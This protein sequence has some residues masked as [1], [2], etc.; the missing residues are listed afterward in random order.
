MKNEVKSYSELIAEMERMRRR[1][2]ELEILE[3]EQK[4]KEKS[5]KK[6]KNRLRTIIDASKDAMIAIDQKGLMTIF[7]PA[8]ERMFGRKKEDM[9]GQPLNCLMPGEYREQHQSF[10]R[11][12]YTRGDPNRAIGKTIELPALGRDGNIFPI[13]LSV[14]VGQ[15]DNE[16][17]VFAV[18]RDIT[19]RK[20]AEDAQQQ[21]TIELQTQNEELDAFA[22][23]VAHDLKDPLAVLIGFADVL[24]RDCARMSEEDIRCY[25]HIIV[26]NGHKINNIIS[27]LLLLASVRK[28]EEIEIYPLDMGRI[29][30]EAQGRLVN[31]I[32]EF[33]AEIAMPDK[34]PKALGYGPWIEEVWVNYFSNAIKYG[35][36][37]PRLQLGAKEDADGSV[38]FWLHDNGQGLTPQQQAKLF[39]PFTRLPHVNSKGH[40][41]GLSIVWRIMKKL[42]GRVGV[43]SEPGQGSTFSFVLPGFKQR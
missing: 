5:I 32:D 22:H 19:K 38:Y 10:V 15:Y 23:T 39:T 25:A 41:L 33:Q 34:W 27:D 43:E 3:A 17:F 30:T 42:G 18:I 13:E 8:A 14:S 31:L 12:F 35:G 11:D 37:P 21:Y 9:I 4:R 26:R 36:K 29:V 2:A 24:E 16:K 7:N 28:K 6:S 1:V 20:L 40:G